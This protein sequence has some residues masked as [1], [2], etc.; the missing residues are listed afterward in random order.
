MNNIAGL[1]TLR[2]F[3]A[4]WVVCF[5][6]ARFPLGN[7]SSDKSLFAN[8]ATALNNGL[9]NGVA[10]VMLFFVMCGGSV[11][12][13]CNW[14]RLQQRLGF[15][16]FLSKRRS[17]SLLGAS[18][19]RSAKDLL[20]CSGRYWPPGQ[21]ASRL[22][23]HSSHSDHDA[24]EQVKWK[25]YSLSPL[26]QRLSFLNVEAVTGVFVDA[27]FGRSSRSPPSLLR[28][29]SYDSNQAQNLNATI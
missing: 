6:G 16:I 7:M 8:V 27:V 22:D 10:A 11:Y 24:G 4:A 13:S 18:V 25:V 5:H 17:I 12:G 1:D 21:F 14:A 23:R 2:F 20:W 9:F 29:T 3:A 26:W 28:I 19:P 15:F